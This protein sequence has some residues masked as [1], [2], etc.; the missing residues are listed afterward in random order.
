MENISSKYV[1]EMVC[2]VS[3]HWFSDFCKDVNVSQKCPELTKF[4]AT[5]V[6]KEI[7]ADFQLSP[8]SSIGD[9]VTD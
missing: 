6:F 5:C 8:D 4:L 7:V 9:L 1:T 3:S 2:I